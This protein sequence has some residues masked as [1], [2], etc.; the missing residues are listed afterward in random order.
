MIVHLSEGRSDSLVQVL[1]AMTTRE[2]SV[3]LVIG[4]KLRVLYNEVEQPRPYD[5]DELLG[6]L[7][8]ARTTTEPPSR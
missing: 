8:R 1:G 7:D 3:A 2:Y 6:R 5:M 4:G